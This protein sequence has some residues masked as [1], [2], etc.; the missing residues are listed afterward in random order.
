M[1]KE[2][3]LTIEDPREAMK[4]I[5]QASGKMS[6]QETEDLMAA[7]QKRHNV[8]DYEMAYYPDGRQ[9]AQEVFAPWETK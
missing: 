5:L 6:I 3:V 1:D 9:V 7:Y 8:E 2:R 4:E